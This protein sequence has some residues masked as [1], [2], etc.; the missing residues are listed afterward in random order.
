MKS[1]IKNIQEEDFGGLLQN[2]LQKKFP[3]SCV[4]WR[5]TKSGGPQ[6]NLW[7]TMQE[8]VLSEV[9]EI[10]AWLGINP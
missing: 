6:L 8:H 9:Q 1:L 4:H 10:Q 2:T 5:L 3:Q 7:Q